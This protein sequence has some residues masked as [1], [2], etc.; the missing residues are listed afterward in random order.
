MDGVIRFK[1]VYGLIYIEEA[2]MSAQF[3]TIGIIGRIDDQGTIETLTSLIR[4]MHQL[5]KDI[6]VEAITASALNDSSLKAY[7]REQLCQHCDLLMVVGGDGTL[8]HAAHLGVQDNIPVIGINRGRLGFLTDIRPQELDKLKAILDG[9]YIQEKRFL[10]TAEVEHHGKILGN[11]QALNE[12][13]LI[14]DSAPHMTEFEIFIDNKFVCSQ[15]SDGL[16]VATPTGS[17]AY[18]LSGG[19]P[20]LHPKLDALVIVPMFPHTLS[21]RPIVIGGNSVITI[22][23]TPKNTT[24]SRLTY[25]SH[26]YVQTMPGSHITISKKEQQLNLIHPLDYDYYESLR[27]KLHW[28]RK[29]NYTE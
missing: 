11:G 1:V 12:I 2:F 21:M 18:A 24:S 4:L 8:L 22:V 9:Q 19:G 28:G 14:P 10:L 6:V 27:S 29:L 16:I 23:I 3:N 26:H 25:D 15:D 5:K 7:P 17:T 20:I 13:A